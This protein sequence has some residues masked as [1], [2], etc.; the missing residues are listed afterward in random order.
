MEP[1]L[2]LSLVRNFCPITTKSQHSCQCLKSKIKNWPYVCV[3]ECKKCQFFGKF[4]ECAKWMI[5][6]CNGRY[7]IHLLSF[8][9]LHQVSL[10][11]EFLKNQIDS[12]IS[13]V[14]MRKKI[15]FI[16]LGIRIIKHP[17][18]VTLMQIWKSLYMFVFI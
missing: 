12:F 4:C 9:F 16:L 15:A 2:L 6:Y 18:K 10:I 1:K 8:L 11:S 5:P 17:L 14:S 13:Y 3:S 7:M